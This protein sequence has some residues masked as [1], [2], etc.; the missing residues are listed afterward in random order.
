VEID[1]ID[2]RYQVVIDPAANDRMYAHFAFLAQVSEPAAQRLLNTLVQDIQS[3]ESM[4]TSNS[5][6]ERS[7]LPFGK[8][9]YKLSAKR[10]RIVYQIVNSTV[11]V[12][13][14]QDCRQSDD[15]NLL[16]G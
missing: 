4:P 12:D 16:H 13:D 9:R 7:F 5:P 1:E 14:I 3:L 11:Y 6:F 15:A 10:Y 8:Y 2:R